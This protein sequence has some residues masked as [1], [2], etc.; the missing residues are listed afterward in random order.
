MLLAH[1]PTQDNTIMAVSPKY[2]LKRRLC[3][4]VFERSNVPIRCVK[5]G[6]RAGTY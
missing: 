2:V 4:G 1:S 3:V 6:S 5:L